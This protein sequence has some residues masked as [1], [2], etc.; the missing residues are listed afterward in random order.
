MQLEILLAEEILTGY[1]AIRNKVRQERLKW[2]ETKNKKAENEGQIVK[3]LETF[4]VSQ[5]NSLYKRIRQQKCARNIS[6]RRLL[7]RYQDISSDLRAPSNVDLDKATSPPSRRYESAK[8][9][10]PR[11]KTHSQETK[12]VVSSFHGK[13]PL[14]EYRAKIHPPSKLVLSD[15]EKLVE[16]VHTMKADELLLKT[17]VQLAYKIDKNKD[18]RIIDQKKFIDTYTKG[19]CPK[20]EKV[21][22]N[23]SGHSSKENQSNHHHSEV[24]AWYQDP[25]TLYEVERNASSTNYSRS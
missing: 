21:D 6:E 17:E 5:T 15:K 22:F 2:L 23:D 3:E 24:L 7:K 4:K 1:W 10:R 18:I 19:P 14:K 12:T 16:R 25:Q 9:I 13:I 20:H 8:I 11:P